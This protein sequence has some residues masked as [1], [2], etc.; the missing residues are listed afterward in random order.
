VE[1]GEFHIIF[2]E[3]ERLKQQEGDY[4]LTDSGQKEQEEIYR[5]REIVAEIQQS[6]CS[7]HTST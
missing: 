3:L 1:R 2:K 7:F 4:L 6:P 5:L